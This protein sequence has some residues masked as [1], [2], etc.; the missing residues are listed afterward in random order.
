[1]RLL[2]GLHYL[3]LSE[4]IDPWGD[5]RAVLGERRE[6]MRR[7]VSEQVVQTNEV[8]RSWGL[9]P[10]FLLLADEARRP[11]DLVELGPSA[12]LNLVW[13][14]YRYRFRDRTWG[15]E[16]APLELVGELRTPFP[17]ELLAVEPALRR[18]RGIDLNPVD[19]TT[20]EGARL[21]ECFVWPDQPE[22]LE[23]LRRAV[24]ALRDEPPELIRGNYADLLPG[25]LEDRDEDA[26][27]VVFQ[28]ASLGYLS[29][30][31][32]EQLFADIECAGREAPLAFLTGAF[33]PELEGCWPLELTV[34][35]EG[36]TRRLALQDFHGAWLDW[37][38][39]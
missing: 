4:G 39:A 16:E 32:R 12:G 17:V 22:R 18:R 15:P 1:L 9:L 35:P 20:E 23:R 14:R 28:T 34:W 3:A 7:F 33:D 8:Q 24:E 2:G 6:W 31:R 26:L 29:D 21:L 37:Q 25:L 11:L 36:E 13:D 30:D 19:V 27:T 10:A 5:V 38:A